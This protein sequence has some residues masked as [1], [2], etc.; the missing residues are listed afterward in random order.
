MAGMEVTAK[1]NLTIEG[2]AAQVSERDILRGS[3]QVYQISKLRTTP[4][5]TMNAKHM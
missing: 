1:L 2:Y 5:Q 3:V 4:E